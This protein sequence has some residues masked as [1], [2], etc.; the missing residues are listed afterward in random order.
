MD[1]LVKSGP[2]GRRSLT[3]VLL[4]ALLY[5]AV[6]VLALKLA[7][8]PAY[9]SPLY[10]SAGIALACTL[11]FGRV[12]LP[13]IWLGAA[14]A[15]AT[16]VTDWA[17]TARLT[18]TLPLIVG[19]G[20]AAQA[21]AGAALMQ[22]FIRQPLVLSA[23]RDILLASLLGAMVACTLSASVATPALWAAGV[24]PAG[25]LLDTWLT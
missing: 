5:G 19:L 21:W 22:R 2:S 7:G 15:D 4:T 14:L 18:Q 8:P 3:I 17:G 24:L 13:G 11:V 23:P 1:Q 16:L 25:E 20:A 6:G 9:A 10:P 12:A